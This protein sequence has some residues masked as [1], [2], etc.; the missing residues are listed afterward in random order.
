MSETVYRATI[1]GIPRTK[2]TSNEL[3]LTVGKGHVLEWVQKL[4]EETTEKGAIRAVLSRVRV[5]PSKN[6]RKWT[7]LAV[8]QW[9][10]DRPDGP[11]STPVGIRALIYRD[12]AVGDVQGFQQAIGDYLQLEKVGVLANDRLIEHWDGTRRLKDAA[13][14]RIELEITVLDVSREN[15]G[16]RRGPRQSDSRQGS[17]ALGDAGPGRRTRVGIRTRERGAD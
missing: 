7:R 6:Y 1:H 13:H 16:A 9:H 15:I 17:L 12:R 5:Q 4:A 11:I 8:F 2:K 10:G 14:P 3:H